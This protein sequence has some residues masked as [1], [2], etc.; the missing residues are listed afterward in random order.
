MVRVIHNSKQFDFFI[1]YAGPDLAYAEMLRDTLQ[2]AAL[3]FLAPESELL[4]EDW[5]TRL[6]KAIRDAWVT[7]VII[8]RNTPAAHFQMEEYY[9][10]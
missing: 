6:P 5:P 2:P 4:G 7:L 9:L 1:S 3:I 10:P 8:S